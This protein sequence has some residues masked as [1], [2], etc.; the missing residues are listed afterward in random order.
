M[1]PSV[2]KT[3]LLMFM[4][5]TCLTIRVKGQ[6]DG[7]M[8]FYGSQM[9]NGRLMTPLTMLPLP[10]P[11][12][13]NPD[14]A[15][16]ERQ[17]PYQFSVSGEEAT[18]TGYSGGAAEINIP[19]TVSDGLNTYR[20]TGIGSG[21]FAKQTNLLKAVIPYGVRT[22]E[23]EAFIACENLNEVMLPDSLETIGT[24]AFAGCVSLETIDIPAGVQIIEPEAFADCPRLTS[25]WFLG[26]RPAIGNNAGTDED[27]GSAFPGYNKELKAYFPFGRRGWVP[28]AM[29]IPFYGVTYDANGGS[30]QLPT[31]NSRYLEGDSME[32][33]DAIRRPGKP[34]FTFV[35]WNTRPDGGGID[36]PPGS[37]FIM[38]NTSVTLYVKWEPMGTPQYAYTIIYD[39]NG[40]R[41]TTPQ[42]VTGRFEAAIRL[43]PQGDLERP[44]YLFSGWNTSS[45]GTGQNYPS[46]SF[47]LNGTN[48]NLLLN[49]AVR[50]YARWL[51]YEYSVV[52][53]PKGVKTKDTI[54]LSAVL[55]RGDEPVANRRLIFRINGAIVGSAGTDAAGF[56]QLSGVKL[57]EPAGTYPVEVYYLADGKEMGYGTQ[58][59]TVTSAFSPPII[60][61]IGTG[62]LAVAGA[63]FRTMN[64]RKKRTPKPAEGREEPE[65]PSSPKA[66]GL[67]PGSFTTVDFPGRCVLN[68]P[69]RLTLGL[70]ESTTEFKDSLEIVKKLVPKGTK[71]VD[72][73]FKVTAPGYGEVYNDTLVP[74]GNKT[75]TWDLSGEFAPITFDVYPQV[76]GEQPLEV[77]VYYEGSR[78]D[79]TILSANVVNPAEG[80]GGGSLPGK[81]D[82]LA[83]ESASE[84]FGNL[85]AAAGQDKARE[86]RTLQVDYRKAENRIIYQIY[87]REYPQSTVY[88][89]DLPNSLEDMVQRI[90]VF[91]DYLD[92][93][94]KKA[95][96]PEAEW[97][98]IYMNLN[99]RCQNL[100]HMII[101]EAIDEIMKTWTNG[102][103]VVISTNEQW[104]PWEVF[105]DG[106]DY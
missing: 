92:E 90:G 97:D 75:M 103:T 71:S 26:D 88:Y 27:W 89:V 11:E 59:M 56:A 6:T 105:H 87:A 10:R 101:P 86:I 74:V 94:V 42:A 38:G 63:A 46:G 45:A 8:D 77:E 2:F 39:I 60:W 22:I 68:K 83:M 52:N 15:S 78:V 1:K 9:R 24:V 41:G 102:S 51:P 79:Y 104:I 34:D 53:V 14:L 18:I 73:N 5:M 64:N 3:V 72:L 91:T 20:V 100:Y 81:A 49:G 47:V 25:V 40:G 57:T 37:T 62:A 16:F 29:V 55:R 19:D 4:V 7:W 76:L 67:I 21:A 61:I 28:S 93:I 96:L 31:D 95:E 69:A 50:L 85:K 35:S 23:P 44:G 12:L 54:S 48:E 66:A 32:V 58:D 33:Y 80:L 82:P 65:E 13:A 106:T 98:A 30:G 70:G 43:P 36:Y 99:F 84:N 17:A